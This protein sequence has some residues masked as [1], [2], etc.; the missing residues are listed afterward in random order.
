[1]FFQGTPEFDYTVRLSDFNASEEYFDYAVFGFELPEGF[2]VD[3]ES[4]R[5]SLRG[6]IS[7]TS[8]APSISKRTANGGYVFFRGADTSKLSADAEL[9]TVKIRVADTFYHAQTV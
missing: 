3:P 8:E 5:T 4:V 1:M 2:T 7:F 9:F 6:N